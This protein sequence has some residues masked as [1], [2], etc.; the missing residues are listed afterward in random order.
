MRN[1]SYKMACSSNGRSPITQIGN[2]WFEPTT[3]HQPCYLRTI[4]QRRRNRLNA[5]IPLL[6]PLTEV[7]PMWRRGATPQ[8]NRKLIERRL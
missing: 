8:G 3:R 6:L 5:M 7:A 4:N 1:Q 2:R